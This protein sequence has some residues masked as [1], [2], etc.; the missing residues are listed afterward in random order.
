MGDC[1]FMSSEN[2]KIVC[3]DGM[4]SAPKNPRRILR[5]IEVVN[6][7][8]GHISILALGQFRFKI[9]LQ[10]VFSAIVVKD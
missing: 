6:V 10:I 4:K 2:R 3:E 7:A 5:R 8:Q 1:G 9:L